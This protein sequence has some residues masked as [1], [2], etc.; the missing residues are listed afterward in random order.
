MDAYTNVR[1]RFVVEALYGTGLRVAGLCGLHLADLH[2][3]D[4]QLADLQL[5]PSSAHLGCQV[6]R[7]APARDPP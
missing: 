6:A 7:G 4:L 5:V 2:L 3:A 1:D